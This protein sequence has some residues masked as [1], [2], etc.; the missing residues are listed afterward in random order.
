[1]KNKHSHPPFEKMWVN[2]SDYHQNDRTDIS[3]MATIEKQAKPVDNHLPLSFHLPTNSSFGASNALS[4][5]NRGEINLI[6]L[7]NPCGAGHSPSGNC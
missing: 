2:E 1:L 3:G 6:D 5:R 4:A 7:R